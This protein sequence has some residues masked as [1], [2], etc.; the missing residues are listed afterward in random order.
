MLRHSID[1]VAY[2]SLQHYTVTSIADDKT[3]TVYCG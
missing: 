2:D 3:F 1:L